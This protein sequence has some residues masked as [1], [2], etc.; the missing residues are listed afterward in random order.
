ME[1][2]HES[3]EFVSYQGTGGFI[4]AILEVL[5]ADRVDDVLGQ[6]GAILSHELFMSSEFVGLEQARVAWNSFGILALF[7]YLGSY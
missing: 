4:A 2:Q 6:I 1:I 7:T 5:P 3:V